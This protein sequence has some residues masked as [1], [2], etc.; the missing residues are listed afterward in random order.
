MQTRNHCCFFLS[1]IAGLLI[2]SCQQ[3]TTVW[4]G[5]AP[6]RVVPTETV[7][8]QLQ[9][10]QHFDVGA[11]IVVSNTFE[12]ARMNGVSLT[13]DTLLTVLI[14]PENAPINPSPWYAFSLVAPEEQTLTLKLTYSPGSFHR[15]YPKVS[16][17]GKNWTN[18]D[19]A[20][21]RLIVPE[22]STPRP[23]AA[24]LRLTLS[25]DT[26]WIAAQE[27]VGTRPVREW[28]DKLAEKPH[29]TKQV[30]GQS[31]EGRELDLLSIGDPK[32]KKLLMIMGLQHPPEIPGYM[33]M[34]AFVETVA[35]DSDLARRF[36]QSYTTMVV[37]MVNPDGVAH[38]HWRHN[39]GGVDINRD[40]QNVHQPEIQ[41]VQAYMQNTERENGAKFYVAI[42]FHST[43]E[44]IYYT[45][46]PELLGN[47]PGIIPEMIAA[48]GRD[49]PGYEPNV[50]PSPGSGV[51]VT[52]NSYF[53]HGHRAEALTYEVGDNTP[54]EFI[55][56]KAV[57]T[58][59]RL[60][61]GMLKR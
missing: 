6:I 9:L 2:I 4:K 27:S 29:V 10:K 13:K 31:H 25:P 41:A 38:G 21:Y 43:W 28:T 8:I 54:R 1:L 45:V 60:M 37:P 61:E 20:A 26:L 24:L 51:S 44:D 12:G 7:P 22:D 57:A 55:R 39:R 14:S 17:D 40:W 58:A 47:M 52:S 19:S 3:K 35:G 30:I 36:R 42:D 18:L 34:Q 16:R 49:L 50:R 15:Y 59:N 32:S 48:S 5:Q 56:A 11:G 33:A 46:N 53:F 23:I